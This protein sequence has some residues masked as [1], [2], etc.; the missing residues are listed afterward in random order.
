MK[1][2]GARKVRAGSIALALGIAAGG[3]WIGAQTLGGIVLKSNVELANTLNGGNASILGARSLQFLGA[4][5]FRAAVPFAWRALRHDPTVIS[6]V[7]A[8]G[9]TE[10]ATGKTGRV[11]RLLSY[12][13]KLSRRD[14]RTHLWAIENYVALGDT[15]PV[16][17]EYD[18]AL[19]TSPEAR[20]LLF[21]ILGNAVVN[22]VVARDLLPR[23]RRKPPWYD[24]FQVY[25]AT[26]Q[27]VTPV[28]AVAFLRMARGAGLAIP[29]TGLATLIAR[30]LD[31]GQYSTA[32]TAYRLK[33][34]GAD[35]RGLRDPDFTAI[36]D[37]PAPFDWNLS[38]DGSILARAA[39][40]NGVGRLE[41]EAGAGSTGVAARQGQ[42][43]PPG[44]YRLVA[45]ADAISQGASL[46]WTLTCRDGPELAKLPMAAN[47]A[48][49]YA[50]AGFVVPASCGMQALT[51]TADA[52][53]NP[54]GL[55][56]AITKV[57]IASIAG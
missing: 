45:D 23:L 10:Q 51:L 2:T 50:G 7:Q 43:L 1:S 36:P 15:R 56:T 4:G 29:L 42:L 20:E 38:N 25:L 3:V 19:R 13:Q 6:A 16:L 14:L 46:T 17:R 5:M 24:D 41:V 31:A 55:H 34:P 37:D 30:S 47:K 9:L 8:I 40:Q 48:M 32:W 33:R 44:R 27:R 18:L 35:R 11:D 26:D 54:E 21:P 53:E 39:P 57:M 52:G 22:P 12:A 28:T 49:R